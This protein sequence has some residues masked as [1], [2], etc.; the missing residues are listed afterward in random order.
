M[1][2]K[3]NY[4]DSIIKLK[5][6]IQQLDDDTKAIKYPKKEKNKIGKADYK[7]NSLLQNMN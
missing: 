1:A 4:M 5:T 3:Q 7:I 2:S 6:K